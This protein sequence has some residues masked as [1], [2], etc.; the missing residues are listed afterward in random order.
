MSF[1]HWGLIFWLRFFYGRLLE[2]NWYDDSLLLSFWL[3][4]YCCGDGEIGAL[5]IIELSK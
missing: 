2:H 5:N 4:T 3:L 1:K